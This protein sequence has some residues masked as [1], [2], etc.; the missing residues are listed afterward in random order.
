MARDTRWRCVKIAM[1]MDTLSSLAMCVMVM[2]GIIAH[3][4][5]APAVMNAP[6][7]GVKA[8]KNVRIAMVPAER[9]VLHVA[10]GLVLIQLVQFV[11]A[12]DM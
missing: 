3:H 2:A 7:V 5:M 6:G 10:D 8:V 12:G 4:V 1:A 11:L 9:R